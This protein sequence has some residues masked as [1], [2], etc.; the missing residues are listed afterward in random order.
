MHHNDTRKGTE[1]STMKPW[2]RDSTTYCL[3]HDW[4][5][6][7]SVVS[8]VVA[9]P[10]EIGAKGPHILAKSGDNSRV[11]ISLTMLARSAIVPNS[12]PRYCVMKMLDRE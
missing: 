8:I 11:I 5:M 4:T 2:N 7:G 6:I 3:P 12:A 9:P 10:A 1:K